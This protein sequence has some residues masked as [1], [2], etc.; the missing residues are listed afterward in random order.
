MI[1]ISGTF[2]LKHELADQAIKAMLT[3]QS[4]SV[5]ED[6]CVHYRFMRSLTD[7]NMLHVFEEWTSL[8]AL[9][10]HYG[11][12]HVAHF[13]TIFPA[14]LAVPADVDM[15]DASHKRVLQDPRPLLVGRHEG[16]ADSERSPEHG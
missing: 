13:N 10:A 8:D 5:V 1:L 7:A 3:I 11:T 12:D 9:G 16:R 4:A 6:G 15:Y 14:F 2:H